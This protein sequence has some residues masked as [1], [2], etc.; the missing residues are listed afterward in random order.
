VL[1]GNCF[2]AFPF[3][4]FFFRFDLKLT[5]AKGGFQLV[6]NKVWS[7]I[8]ACVFVDRSLKTRNRNTNERTVGTSK[9]IAKVCFLLLVFVQFFNIFLFS[10]RV[11]QA[12]QH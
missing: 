7:F 9:S 12:E 8:V 2:L 5:H 10:G 11:W 4:L 1:Q 3:S 6:S